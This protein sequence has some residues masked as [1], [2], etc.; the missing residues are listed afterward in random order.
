MELHHRTQSVKLILR[1]PLTTVKLE[2]SLVARIRS[3]E[4]ADKPNVNVFVYRMHVK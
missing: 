4:I 2:E 1:G 3:A